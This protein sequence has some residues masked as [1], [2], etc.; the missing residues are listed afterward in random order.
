MRTVKKQRLTKSS[1]AVL[2]AGLA[3]LLPGAASADAGAISGV[4]PVGDGQVTATYTATFSQCTS[5]Y[6]GWFPQAAQVPSSM[7][8]P[9][10]IESTHITYVGRNQDTSGTQTGTDTFYPAYSSTRLCLYAYH[11]S[12]DFLLADYVY[13]PA[14]APAPT[15]PGPAPTAAPTQPTTVKPLSIAEARGYVPSVLR[16][17]FGS[18]FKPS[19]LTRSCYRLTS[20]KVRCRVG[21]NRSVWRY[22]GSVTLWNDPGDPVHRFLYRVSVRR[23]F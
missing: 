23:G 2:A 19:S 6:C 22:S 4:A 14:A 1:A 7:A 10:N 11:D 8:C 20:E 16:K 9:A 12:R 13:P 15:A 21:W 17:K 18:R 3:L 5:G